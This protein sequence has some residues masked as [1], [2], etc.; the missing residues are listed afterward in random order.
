MNEDAST[1]RNHFENERVVVQLKCHYVVSVLQCDAR[2]VSTG[3][4]IQLINKSIFQSLFFPTL[5]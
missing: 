5:I 3:G 2:K 1:A 4:I